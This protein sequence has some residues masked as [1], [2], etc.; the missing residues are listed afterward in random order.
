MSLSFQPALLEKV[1]NGEK[2]VTRRKW[3]TNYKVGQ[4]VSVA[5]GMGR[6]ACGR[7]RIVDVSEVPLIQHLSAD[8]ARREGFE[9]GNEFLAY[10]CAV[11]K[12]RV[13][14]EISVARLEFRLLAVTRTVCDCCDGDGTLAVEW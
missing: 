8:E 2:T 5:P 12:K 1:L 9:D 13:V 10:W 6:L 14:P 7:V 11:N 3:P 4:I